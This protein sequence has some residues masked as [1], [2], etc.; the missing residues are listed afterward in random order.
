MVGLWPVRTFYVYLN[1]YMRTNTCCRRSGPSETSVAQ[2]TV[3]PW[4]AYGLIRTVRT[5]P[6][7][8]WASYSQS[9]RCLRL[10][11]VNLRVVIKN[12]IL[13]LMS[14]GTVPNQTVNGQPAAATENGDPTVDGI[15]SYLPG[16]RLSRC[17]CSGET[18]PGP[19]HSDG[20]YGMRLGRTSWLREVLTTGYSWQS[21]ARD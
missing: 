16:Q 8:T 7:L 17:T 19:K 6:T 3:L 4:M 14:A 15:L 18:H 12:R 10:R 13:N 21:C 9:H 5:I 2:A 1:C 11:C 20:S